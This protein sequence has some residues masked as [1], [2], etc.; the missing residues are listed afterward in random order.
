LA[1]LCIPSAVALSASAALAAKPV[2]ETITSSGSG[3]APAG[4]ICDFTYEF[5][6][7][8]TVRRTSFFDENGVL[9]RRI[10]TTEE[11]LLHRNADTG[12]ELTE[13]VHY[14]T[15]LDVASGVVRLTGNF[16][17]LR[18]A[19][20]RIVLVLSG[21]EQFVRATGEVIRATPRVGR[22]F[23]NVICPALGGAP[24]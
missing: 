7:E 19:D 14:T 18:T 4:E 2:H 3:S 12:F 24:A 11:R 10:Q 20:G 1:L 6:F 13:V 23:E 16:W 8:A 22:G 15:D 9:V 5:E 21:L 17:H